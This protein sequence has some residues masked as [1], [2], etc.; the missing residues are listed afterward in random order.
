MN[1]KDF[2]IK[3]DIL[4][5]GNRPIGKL[6][7]KLEF[8]IEGVICDFTSFIDITSHQFGKTMPQI[9]GSIHL[10]IGK[11]IQDTHDF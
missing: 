4:W 2:E 11:F 5:L 8:H 7:Q 6:R 1:F 9:K 10:D 3:G